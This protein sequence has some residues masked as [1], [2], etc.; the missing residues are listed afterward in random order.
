METLS[1]DNH[2]GVAVKGEL[3]D[4]VGSLEEEGVREEKSQRAFCCR[5]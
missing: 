5:E 4:G 2:P 3:R 1:T